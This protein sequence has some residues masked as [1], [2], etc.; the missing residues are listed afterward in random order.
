MNA[1]IFFVA[2]FAVAITSFAPAKKK[3]V[4]DKAR[5]ELKK[6]LFTASERQFKLLSTALDNYIEDDNSA[7]VLEWINAFLESN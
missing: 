3:V 5:A 7:K 2:L 6:K 1:K 4:D